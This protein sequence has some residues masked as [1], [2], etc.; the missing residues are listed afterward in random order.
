MWWL[1]CLK[2]T[3]VFF[4]HSLNG[5]FTDFI[6]MYIIAGYTFPICN[7][8]CCVFWR[9]L[10]CLCS[11]E[12]SFHV[13][14]LL[15][16]MLRAATS[17]HSLTPREK[18]SESWLIKSL[19]VSAEWVLVHILRISLIPSLHWFSNSGTSSTG[20]TQ[21]SCTWRNLWNIFLN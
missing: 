15:R 7:A 3:V 9:K 6:F 20:A 18:L 13:F 21:P 8:G 11:C 2:R 12:V 19:T 5:L 1:K 16:Q 10:V 17:S 4:I 14:F